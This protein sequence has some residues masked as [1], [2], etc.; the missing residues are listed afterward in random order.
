[1]GVIVF[2]IG[3]LPWWLLTIINYDSKI[4]ALVFAIINYDFVHL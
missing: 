3:I 4:L 1:M 2:D